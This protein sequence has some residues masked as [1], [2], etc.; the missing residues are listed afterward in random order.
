M[1]CPSSVHYATEFEIW[2]WSPLYK[3]EQNDPGN[4]SKIK[5]HSVLLIIAAIEPLK[6]L[7]GAVERL[8]QAFV[9]AGSTLITPKKRDYSSIGSPKVNINAFFDELIVFL[10]L[11][12]STPKNIRVQWNNEACTLETVRNN[13]AAQLNEEY[14]PSES[15]GLFDL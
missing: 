11:A 10:L 7:A 4:L 15:I 5:Y 14:D 9:S 2:L 1:K 3:E 8:F 12:W 13:L 6:H